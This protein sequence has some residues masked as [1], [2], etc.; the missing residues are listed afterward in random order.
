MAIVMNNSANITYNYTGATDTSVSNTTITSIAEQHS[1]AAVKLSQNSSWR[2]SENLTYT[3]RVENTGTEPIF[4]IS[5]QD[6]LG[7]ADPQLTFVTGSAKMIIDGV[8][9]P[10]VPTA[11]S[12]LTIVMPGTLAAGDAALFSY[13]AKVVSDIDPAVNE[14]KNTVTVAGHE[15]SAAGPVIT[16]TPSP[17]LTLPK[18]A[19]AEV[20]IEKTV[21][22]ASASV[23]EA[24]TY[25]FRMEN[26]G[27]TEATNVTLRD[28]LPANF[29]VDSIQS[30]TGGVVTD[31][32][33][34][35][36]SLDTDNRL[37][38]PTSTTK[39]ISVPAATAFGSGVTTITIAGTIT[40]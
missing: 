18:A 14:I 30:Q 4:N 40:D 13:I 34:A 10:V 24:L 8:V 26:S 38:L 3:V 19:Y 1:L 36:Y 9:T 22:K 12:P 28:N 35:D 11:V 16:V 37:I 31:Y 6:D 17:S 15:T 5:I 29:Q 23:G 32:T 20:R 33:A 39:L 21:D 25:V 7:G 27:N 2:P